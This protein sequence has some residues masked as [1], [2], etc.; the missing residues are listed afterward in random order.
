MPPNLFLSYILF[1]ILLFYL[2]YNTF[3]SS[4]NCFVHGPV[5]ACCWLIDWYCSGT[6]TSRAPTRS[7]GPRR[8]PAGSTSWKQCRSVSTNCSHW[9]NY[10]GY[11]STVG[12]VGI[13][14]LSYWFGGAKALTNNLDRRIKHSLL[15]TKLTKLS[16]EWKVGDFVD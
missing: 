8:E 2:L 13:R 14:H 4:A 5:M 9:K 7:S 6:C 1:F 16:S 3:I 15:L 11:C 12:W 10:C